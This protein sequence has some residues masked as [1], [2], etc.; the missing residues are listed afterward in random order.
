MTTPNVYTKL[1]EELGL[2]KSIEKLVAKYDDAEVSSELARMQVVGFVRIKGAL[3]GLASRTTDS[4]Q[5]WL[6]GLLSDVCSLSLMEKDKGLTYMPFADLGD[7][8]SLMLQDVSADVAGILVGVIDKI[9][10][11]VLKS[12][13]A[14]VAFL[15]CA[16]DCRKGLIAVL[17]ATYCDMPVY[18]FRSWRIFGEKFWRRAVEFGKSV[19]RQGATIIEYVSRSLY[20]SLHD[21][22]HREPGAVTDIVGF[23][24]QMKLGVAENGVLLQDTLLSALDRFAGEAAYLGK[25]VCA[26]LMV[27]LQKTLGDKQKTQEVL[28]KRG[29]VWLDDA[30]YWLNKGDPVISAHRAEVAERYYKQILRSERQGTNLENRLKRAIELKRS[31]YAFW[32]KN[33]K[34]VQTNKIDMSKQ[35]E[36]ARDFVGVPDAN[37]AMAR[38]VGVFDFDLESY[39]SGLDAYKKGNLAILFSTVQLSEDGRVTACADDGS[40]KSS[41][42]QFAAQ[43]YGYYIHSRIWPAYKLIKQYNFGRRY[44]DELVATSVVV[45]ERRRRSVSTALYLGFTG[46]FRS[47]VVLLV[48]QVDYLL[49]CKLQAAGVDVLHSVGGTRVENYTVLST[50]LEKP[51]CVRCLDASLYK[52]LLLLFGSSPYFNIRN[53]YAHGN[54]DDPVDGE[55]SRIDM[56]IWWRFLKFVY[57]GT[58]KCS[59]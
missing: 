45:P 16:N 22:D 40:G 53:E 37:E 3:A 46:E 56:Y 41:D 54:V 25:D 58:L 2:Q 28:A 36:A 55:Y 23:L 10:N 50:L 34:T 11:P 13:V 6:Y 48:P 5:A 43:W 14:D 30:E 33:L 29:D 49:R 38:F 20:D 42:S 4:E 27:D 26:G 52:E 9:T 1:I 59:E 21:Y 35:V 47:A 18:D 44:F 32:S 31:G 57:H 15:R 19:G 7:R 24:I 12:R 8:C 51:E 17:V 39:D